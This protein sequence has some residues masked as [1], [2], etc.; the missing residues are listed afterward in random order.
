MIGPLSRDVVG[1]AAPRI[2]GGP[3]HAGLALRALRHEAVL[4]AKCGAD[5]RG[6]YQPR[7]AAL[8]LPLALAS[9]GETTTFSFSYDSDGGRRMRVDAIGEPWR[10]GDVPQA[11][12]RGVE[13]LHVAPLLRDDFDPELLGWL[14]RGRR[15]LMDGQGLVRPRREGPLVLDGAFDTAVLR[16]LT[17][18]KLSEEEASVVGDVRELDVPELLVTLG[19]RG[20]RVVTRGAAEFVPARAVRA[21]PTGAGDA[22]C[23]AYAASR[24]EGHAP[25]SA[26]RRATALV[27]AFLS[28]RTR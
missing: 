3:W 27:A 6:A 21:E 10:D 1:G 13:W 5:D 23:A 28:T 19:E 12:L 4:F 26:A 25:V 9:A 16:H 11:L 15:L 20:S 8:G 22:F 24:A 2:G 7:V 14:A 18:L 17:V